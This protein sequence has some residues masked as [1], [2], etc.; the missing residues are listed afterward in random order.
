MNI[1]KK[2]NLIGSIMLTVCAIVWGSSF[3]AQTT[4]AE[5]V[6]PFTFISL[7]SLLGSIALIP[8][9]FVM[10]IFRKKEEASGIIR[11]ISDVAEFN[12]DGSISYIFRKIDGKDHYFSLSKRLLEKLDKNNL[13]NEFK[14]VFIKEV[15][16]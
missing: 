12:E 8:V 6:G 2:N 5:Y 4:G 1:E 3:V 9:I 7:R 16:V 10:G 15:K 13:S 14:N 11:Y